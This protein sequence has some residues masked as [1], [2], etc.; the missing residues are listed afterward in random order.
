M[1]LIPDT[2][3]EKA[4]TEKQYDKAIN[5]YLKMSDGSSNRLEILNKVLD[6]AEHPSVSTKTT[7]KIYESLFG[8][9]VL[10]P[11]KDWLEKSFSYVIKTTPNISSDSLDKAHYYIEFAKALEKMSSNFSKQGFILAGEQYSFAKAFRDARTVYQHINE[12]SSINDLYLLELQE[13]CV[14]LDISSAINLFNEYFEWNS[15]CSFTS[16]K[17]LLETWIKISNQA[18]NL[19]SNESALPKNKM[20]INCSDLIILIQ[21]DI[22]QRSLQLNMAD[23]TLWTAYFDLAFKQ[24][25]LPLIDYWIE[26]SLVNKLHSKTDLGLFI[27]DHFNEANISNIIQLSSFLVI[28]FEDSK[29][30]LEKLVAHLEVIIEKTDLIELK[31]EATN[32]IIKLYQLL[33]E[34]QKNLI[35]KIKHVELLYRN[36][37][38]EE[39]FKEIQDI[40]TRISGDHNF[41]TLLSPYFLAIA[42]F[43]TQSKNYPDAEEV[44]ESLINLYNSINDRIAAGRIY[45]EEAS[46]FF[47]TERKNANDILNK[48]MQLLSS[49]PIEAGLVQQKIGENLFNIGRENL[50][51][52]YFVS[53]NKYFQQ[54]KSMGREMASNLGK[55][56]VNL[57]RQL[58]QDK[59][60]RKFY[61]HYY[62]LAEKIFIEWGLASQFASDLLFEI[63]RVIE[64]HTD[65]EAINTIAIKTG[66]HIEN[67]GDFLR[68]T[69]MLYDYSSA[70]IEKGDISN[71]ALISQTIFAILEE[72]E[73]SK[74]I[75]EFGLKIALTFFDIKEVIIGDDMLERVISFY[76]DDKEFQAAGD[77]L[78]KAGLILVMVERHEQAV[79]TFG[80][81]T[82]FY[83]EANNSKAIEDII[84]KC[85]DIAKQ[86]SDKNKVEGQLYISKANEI[87]ENTN[88]EISETTL[89]SAYSNYT[90]Y[91]LQ[92]SQSMI[93]QTTMPRRKHKKKEWFDKTQKDSNDSRHI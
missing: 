10:N 73:S 70:L 56:L 52:N 21:K 42:K 14:E 17:I 64:A 41:I 7:K 76:E 12:S 29:A 15:K 36:R 44:F 8:A 72:H 61:D 38:K 81:A 78:Y 20:K 51:N 22:W 46:L 86:L 39:A 60:R 93:H 80:R 88:T 34:K 58:L 57:S 19:L 23:L 48:S 31:L 4:L 89:N 9:L 37:S 33:E 50:A 16:S 79:A 18:L 74:L 13:L 77:A 1:S 69:A 87:I 2:E 28:R 6:L 63:K 35:W 92:Q 91:L 32:L 59:K 65:T 75:K 55:L 90:E 67:S 43:L 85:L 26:Q 25:I 45:G 49:Y 27:I 68:L 40:Q 5:I 71:G 82:S 84:V 53:S 3:L 83:E 66:K 54:D 11:P 24:Q 30:V 47:E 62:D